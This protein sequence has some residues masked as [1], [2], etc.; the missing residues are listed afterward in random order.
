M[1]KVD[2]DSRHAPKVWILMQNP[3][4]VGDL[5]AVLSRQEKVDSEL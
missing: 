4:V 2:P 1:W 5:R 3:Y